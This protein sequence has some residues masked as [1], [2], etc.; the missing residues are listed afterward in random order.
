MSFVRD[1]KDKA[2][3]NPK[4][5]DLNFKGL[6]FEEVLADLLKIKPV[7]NSNLKKDAPKKKSKLKTKTGEK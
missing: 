5:K 4:E 6:E 1:N 2:G 3:N 7:E